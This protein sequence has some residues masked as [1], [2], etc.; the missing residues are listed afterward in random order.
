MAAY[1]DLLLC[2]MQSSYVMHTP[3]EEI[4]ITDRKYYLQS[5]DIYLGK[6]YKITLKLILKL[7]D[8]FYFIK[9]LK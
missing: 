2:F 7:I 9:V 6:K 1:K 3:P 5:K 4:N 8:H